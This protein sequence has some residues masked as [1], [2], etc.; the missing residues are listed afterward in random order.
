MSFGVF[1][2]RDTIKYIFSPTVL[3][4]SRSAERRVRNELRQSTDSIFEE[5]DFTHGQTVIS[6]RVRCVAFEF[7]DYPFKPP[8]CY[9]TI[10]NKWHELKR[11]LPDVPLDTWSR[12]LL[13][14][15]FPEF[16]TRYGD[17]DVC[18]CC[19]SCLCQDKWCVT[20]RLHDTVRE[21]L[22]LAAITRMNTDNRIY[23][24]GQMIKRLFDR[25]PDEIV[26]HIVDLATAH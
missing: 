13:A 15:V 12:R 9:V 5:C 17:H 22:L 14:L 11:L 24:T 21:C 2:K 23:A 8:K 18:L 26:L 4:M 16:K 1:T 7:V 20:S 3:E 6:M 19:S 10:D 25:L